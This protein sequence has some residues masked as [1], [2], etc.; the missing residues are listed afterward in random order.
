MITPITTNEGR[1]WTLMRPPTLTLP[2]NGGGDQS[3]ALS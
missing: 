3:G 1:A 2:H